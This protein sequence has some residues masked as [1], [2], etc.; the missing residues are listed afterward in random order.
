MEEAVQ[1]LW[2]SK[3]EGETLSLL[4]LL[5]PDYWIRAIIRPK[6]LSNQCRVVILRGSISK[7]NLYN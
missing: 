1:R 4:A 5:S 7:I 6:K 3:R 2:R